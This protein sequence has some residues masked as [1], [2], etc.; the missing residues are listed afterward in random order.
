VKPTYPNEDEVD[1]ETLLDAIVV[2]SILIFIV[3]V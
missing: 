2:P 3:P 1:I